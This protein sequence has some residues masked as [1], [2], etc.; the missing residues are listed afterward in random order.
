MKY[1]VVL[2]D[3]YNSSITIDA[4][5]IAI[6]DGGTLG[7]VNKDGFIIKALADGQWIQVDLMTGLE[8]EEEVVENE[9]A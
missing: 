6:T 3:R 7:F 5:T 1:K 8:E 2:R 9:T 4:E